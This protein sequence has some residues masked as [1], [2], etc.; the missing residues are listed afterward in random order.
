LIGSFMFSVVWSLG[1][2]I[3]GAS[4]DKFDCFIRDLFK[5]KNVMCGIPPSIDKSEPVL[6][7]PENNTVYDYVF[8][9]EKNEWQTWISM[10]PSD[11]AIPPKARFNEIIIPTLDTV[12]YRQI[13]KV[14]VEGGKHVLFVGPTGTGK[15]L[16]ISDTLLNFLSSN[17][18]PLSITFSAQTSAKQTQAI[19]ESKLEKRRKGVYGPSLGKKYLIF[20]L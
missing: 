1:A 15:S 2:T 4:R 12:R 8:S 14:L 7:W 20:L 9:R 11:F 5:G 13:L 19:I 6:S 16:S 3:N 17:F 18:S 10:I